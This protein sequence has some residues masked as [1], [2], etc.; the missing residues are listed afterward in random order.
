MARKSKVEDA[1]KLEKNKKSKKRAVNNTAQQKKP[2]KT[3]TIKI[4]VQKMPTAKSYKPKKGKTKRILKWVGI[5]CL[6][7]AAIVFLFTTP[8][9]N[10]TEIE[11]IGNKNVST[12]EIQ[13]LSQIKLNENMFKFMKPPIIE[14]IKG[15]A[16]IEDVKVSRVLPNKMQITVQEREVK[17]MVKL[18]NNFAYI[19]SQGYILDIT[20]QTKEVPTLEGV[21]TPEEEIIV[22]KRLNTEDLKSL[23]AVLRIINSCEEN[24]ISRYITGINISNPNEYTIT[25]GEK[26]KTIHLGNSSNLD[27]KI[28]YVK[29]ILQAEEG[30]EGDIFVNG[31]LNNGFQPFFREKV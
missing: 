2:L 9:F 5:I 24:E 1:E 16:Y 20:E 12:E 29:A 31:D 23:E 10:V 30:N 7:A 28:L 15:N 19:N 18:L 26:G 14:N 3:S 4:K 17:F 11:V 8:L 25:M 27:T 21:S 13:S 22:G 6:F